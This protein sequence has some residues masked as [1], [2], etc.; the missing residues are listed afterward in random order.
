MLGFPLHHRQALGEPVASRS[1]DCSESPWRRRAEGLASRRASAPYD[2]A[3]GR[4]FGSFGDPAYRASPVSA[5]RP[6]GV[7]SNTSAIRRAPGGCFV[8]LP[9]R[10]PLPIALALRGY[11]AGRRRASKPPA[12]PSRAVRISSAAGDAA[13]STGSGGGGGEASTDPVSPA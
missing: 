13:G 12:L 2:G 8:C 1:R 10:L 4:G 5:R 7:E 3:S 11:R 6:Y 9:G